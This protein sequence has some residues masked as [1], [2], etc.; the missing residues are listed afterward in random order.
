MTARI[1]IFV[2]L[3]VVVRLAVAET[4]GKN[5]IENRTFRPVGNFE[6][7]QERKIIFGLSVFYTA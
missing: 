6:A 3:D 4:V 5:L 2:I 7:G 1:V